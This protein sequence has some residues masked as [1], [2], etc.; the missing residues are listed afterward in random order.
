MKYLRTRFK[1]RELVTHYKKKI[2]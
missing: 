2:I 1:I